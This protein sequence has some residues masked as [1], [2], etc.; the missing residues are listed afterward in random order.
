MPR[1]NFE[2][3]LATLIPDFIYQFLSNEYIEASSATC[4]AL[5][6]VRD[7][8]DADTSRELEPVRKF[9]AAGQKETGENNGQE[10]EAAPESGPDDLEAMSDKL[11]AEMAEVDNEYYH[12]YTPGELRF[13]FEKIIENIDVIYPGVKE[14]TGINMALPIGFKTKKGLEANLVVEFLDID[15]RPEH[16]ENVYLISMADY[17][18]SDRKLARAYF[19]V[20]NKKFKEYEEEF[21]EAIKLI[22]LK[23]PQH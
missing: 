21:N 11:D 23:P 9:L 19:R 4:M 8:V 3:S 5:E 10:E 7:V 22:K 12:L 16:L 1:L 15:E 14:K 17:M 18:V 6:D 13:I 2:L 20:D